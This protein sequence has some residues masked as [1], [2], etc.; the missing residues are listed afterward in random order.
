MVIGNIRQFLILVQSG[1]ERGEEGGHAL[2]S[3]EEVLPD[4]AWIL[5]LGQT[6]GAEVFV[7]CE[8]VFLCAPNDHRSNGISAVNAA[9]QGEALIIVPDERPLKLGNEDFALLHFLE[10]FR[11]PRHSGFAEK[12]VGHVESSEHGE[13]GLEDSVTLAIEAV[14]SEAV[15]KRR[16]R[17]IRAVVAPDLWC[18]IA[19]NT[20]LHIEEI[21]FFRS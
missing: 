1:T 21:P 3:V 17:T 4:E 14:S 16:I 12:R 11:E 5:G 6:K 8:V 13:N 20:F 19:V 18:E 7:G 15:G 10:Q 2:M 9:H